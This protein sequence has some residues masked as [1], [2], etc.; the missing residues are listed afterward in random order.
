MVEN[1]GYGRSVRRI[2]LSLVVAAA[3]TACT[4]SPKTVAPTATTDA[5]QLPSDSVP[6]PGSCDPSETIDAPTITSS[7]GA[8]AATLGQGLFGCGA[9]SG[10]GFITYS[11]NPV[12]IDTTGPLQIDVGANKAQF[13]WTPGATFTQTGTG[14]WKSGTPA[15]G[16]ARLIIALT[17]PTGNSTATYGADIRVGGA[18]VNCPQ[19]AIDPSDPSDTGA[20]VVETLP[21]LITTA[22][23]GAPEPST[24]APH[25]P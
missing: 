12:L 25:T 6:A 18:N 4:S 21:P 24:S 23:P 1:L 10:N 20:V 15:P 14:H 22:G 17:S 3:L 7:S 11:Y 19:R 13:T 5:A 16:C 9:V 8:V 2:L